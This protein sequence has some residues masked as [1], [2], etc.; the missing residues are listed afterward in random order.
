MRRP[1]LG[2]AA[3]LAALLASTLVGCGGDP[4]PDPDPTSGPRW[5]PRPG[6]AWQ[7]QL[8]GKVDPSADV[9]VYDIDGFENS[10]RDVARLH[11]DGRKVICYIN[12]GAWEDFRPDKDDFP[13]ALLGEKNAASTCAGTRASTRWNPT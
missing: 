12:V 11:R 6:L 5:R 9:P 13:R 4:A 7:W 2:Y 8:D 1:T 3:L 10:A